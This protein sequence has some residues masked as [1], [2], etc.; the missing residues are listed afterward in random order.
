MESNHLIT[1][2]MEII[3]NAGD[4][5]TCVKEALDATTCDNNELAEQKMREA[6]R[7]L[8]KAHLE[9]TET[10]QKEA[11]GETCEY[12]MLFTHAQD[13]LMTIYSE[14]HLAEKLI[15]MYQTLVNK[16]ENTR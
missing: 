15:L 2:A 1:I 6:K 12:S 14:F 7:F 13:T 16:I 11:K 10:I 8:E 3:L 5:R 4:A 9:Q